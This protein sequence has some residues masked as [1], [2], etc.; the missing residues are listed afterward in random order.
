MDGPIG[1]A[2]GLEYRRE[3]SNN[4]LDPITRGILPEGSSLGA[5]QFVGD[6]DP[7]LNSFTSIDNTRRFNTSGSY[8]VREAFAEIRIP[9]LQGREFFEELTLDGAINYADYS[10]SGG[11]TTWKIGGT[12]KP[13]NELSIRGTL[14]QAVRAP[15]I[16]EL[17]D[18]ENPIF[19]GSNQDPCDPGNV[20]LGTNPDIRQANCIAG[21]QAAGVVQ[22]AIVDGAGNY[23]WQNPLTGRFAGVS[24]GNPELDP[25]TSDSYTIGAVFRPSFIDRL[26]ITVDYW[27]IEIENA[28]DAV[29]SGDILDGCYDSADFPNVPFCGSFTRRGDGGLDFLRSGTINFARLEA[30]GVD[31]AANYGFDIGENSFGA[32]LVGS[33]QEKLDRFFN[34]LD[35]TEV[36]PELQEVQRP[37]LSGNLIL[38]WDRGPFGLGF[39]TS[40][41]S[42]QSVDEIEDVLAGDFGNAGFFDETFIFDVNGS[43]ELNDNFSFYGGVNNIADKDPFSTETAWPVGPRG[44]FFF[45]GVNYKM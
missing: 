38:S 41:Q 1:Y 3:S 13:V 30:G 24:G 40:Y 27:N 36:D 5:G 10:T 21:L 34:P 43:Y 39:Q 31:F 28:I 44:R 19:I 7:F 22:S 35:L 29:A 32:R 33:Y 16:A 2:A 17:F 14:S 25:E 18:P 20:G 9:I 8:D 26:S 45:L 6:V 23:I 11:Q 4:E 15:N 12:W 37:E 42:K